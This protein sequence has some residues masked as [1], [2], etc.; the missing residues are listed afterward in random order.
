MPKK[1]NLITDSGCELGQDFVREHGVRLLS[2]S[3]MEAGKPDGGLH[4]VDDMFESTSSDDFYEAMR[5]GAAPS[6]SQPSQGS[7]E[8]CFRDAMATG[9]PSVYLAFSSGISGCYEGAMVA[10]ERVVEE[11]GEGAPALEVIDLKCAST[12]QALFVDEAVSQWESGMEFG[13]FLAWVD[14][15]SWNAQTI[16][17]LDNFDA[18][19]RGGRIPKGIASVGG[20]LDVKPLL[21]FDQDGALGLAGVAR[22]R[23][24]GIAKMADYFKKYHD[25]SLPLTV[26]IGTAGSD[27]KDVKRLKKLVSAAADG[28][29]RFIETSIGPVI[30]CHVGPGMLSCC[31]WGRGPRAR[32]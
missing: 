19:A 4:G 2:F 25:E 29:V 1:F 9:L 30:G 10:R 5:A 11:A 32:Q 22:G 8:E 12:T 14:E 26:A 28:E 27:A 6:T 16:F 15:W 24:K 20:M 3:Y 13:D 21:T 18:L 7:M 23:R 17:M 31:F